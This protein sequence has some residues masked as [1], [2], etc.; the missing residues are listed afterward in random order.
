MSYPK[1]TGLIKYLVRSI[2]SDNDLVMDFFAGSGTTAAGVLL[3]NVEDGKSR[4]FLLVQIP[5]PLHPD[6]KDQKA[7]AHLCDKLKVA[8]NICELTK[9]Y[10]RR[11]GENI[12]REHPMFASDVG[13]RV[14]KLD[15]TNIREWSPRQED[16]EAALRLSVENV[17]VS[18]SEADILFELLLKYGLDL[19]TP[20]EVRNIVGKKVHSIGGGILMICLEESITTYDAESLGTGM[21]EW[22]KT[23]APAGD[24]VCI[25]RDSAFT[26]DVA[27]TNLSAILQQQ[28]FTNVRS[29]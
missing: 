15:T 4:R 11:I 3:Q 28:G 20:V 16:L 9:E 8:R 22:V 17:K 29:I 5:E 13:Y 21:G 7:G 18:R 12:Q 24:T 19:C 14:L 23:M 26:D 27:K 2:S 25:F 1:P 10:L 6:K